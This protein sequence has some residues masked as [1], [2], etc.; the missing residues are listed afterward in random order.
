M[1]GTPPAYH[2]DPGSGAGN[3]SWIVNLERWRVVQQREDMLAYQGH[4]PRLVGP[5][6]EGDPLHRHHEQQPRR[7]SWSIYLSIR[8]RSQPSIH[9]IRKGY[10]TRTFMYADFYNWNR[11]KIRYCD[12]G[13]FAG[14]TYNKDSGTHLRGQRI[15]NAAV[16]HLLSIGMASA[17]HCCS[18]RCSSGGLAVILHCDQF[19]AFFPSRGATVKCLADAG[20]YLDA[21][22][23]IA[24]SVDVS[25]RRSLRSYFR[26]IVAVQGAAKNLP[27]ACTAR[28]DATSCFFPQN[29]MDDI[30]TPIF[31]LNT[32]YD[33]IQ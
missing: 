23:T 12:G 8:L 25:G 13:S 31:L 9:P 28:L 19:R 26:D 22:C 18:P 30:K 10:F 29:I 17:D 32:A 14:D 6:G 2:L 20:L 33:F 16:R 21:F 24:R 5:H 7:Q 27:P 15:W 3:K 1:D 4:W 11:V